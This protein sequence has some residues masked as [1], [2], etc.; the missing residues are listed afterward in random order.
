MFDQGLE[1][2]SG[3]IWLASWG[4]AG[5]YYSD[6]AGETFVAAESSGPPYWTN[7]FAIAKGADGTLYAA[8]NNGF[9][10]RSADAGISWE[11]ITAFPR[12]SSDGTWSL[13]AHPSMPGTLYARLP[14]NGV[15]VSVDHGA[16]W[17]E[18][19]GAETNDAVVISE[20]RSRT[21]AGL[22]FDIAFP[23]GGD[24]H[25]FTATGRGIWRLPLRPD[26]TASGTWKRLA[27]SRRSSDGSSIPVPEIKKFAFATGVEGFE[28]QLSAPVTRLLVG[29]WGDGAFLTSHPEAGV[30]EFERLALNG[31]HVRMVTGLSNGGFIV[32]TENGIQEVTVASASATS[33][34]NEPS[35]DLPLGFRLGQN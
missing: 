20:A 19:G 22:T 6:D 1:G 14:R 7:I 29:T 13:A 26:G 18:L 34:E 9:L 23:P 24:S 27:V 17:A 15:I 12:V 21:P 30:P 33:A 5:L 25:L 8:A 35:T 2:Q 11:S 10:F 28:E 31:T 4:S 3:R 32:A 16:T